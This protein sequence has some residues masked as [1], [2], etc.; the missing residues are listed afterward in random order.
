MGNLVG[1]TKYSSELA[2]TIGVL[3]VYFYLEKLQITLRRFLSSI[4]FTQLKF[5]Q[6]HLYLNILIL[7]NI[8]DVFTP[9]C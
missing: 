5:Y 3:L 2:A 1:N 8:S 7:H 6:T 4:S 9:F